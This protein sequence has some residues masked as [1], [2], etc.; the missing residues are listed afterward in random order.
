MARSTKVIEVNGE[1]LEVP[2]YVNRTRSGWQARVRHAIGTASQHF[3][4]AHYGGARQSLQ[5][6]ADA[7][8]RFLAQT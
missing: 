8:K 2:M 4:D 7:V 1:T 5:A 3:A 6:A